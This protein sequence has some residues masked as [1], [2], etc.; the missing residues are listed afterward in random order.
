M[1]AKILQIHNEYLIQG[2]EEVVVACEYELLKS[3]GHEV[4]Q[5]IV[6]NRDV[7]TTGGMGQDAVSSW[8]DLGIRL[9]SHARTVA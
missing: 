2:G 5:F 9:S 7:N 4:Q 1:K 3:H 6:R 8:C